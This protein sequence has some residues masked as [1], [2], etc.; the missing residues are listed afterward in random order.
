ML[1]VKG[2][3]GMQDSGPTKEVTDPFLDSS[4]ALSFPAMSSAVGYCMVLRHRPW[5]LFAIHYL[6]AIAHVVSLV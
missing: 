6:S 4:S 5:K 2:E 3:T 1:R